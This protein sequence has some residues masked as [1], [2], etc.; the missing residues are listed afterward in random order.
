MGTASARVVAL[1]AILTTPFLTVAVDYCATD[2]SDYE[3]EETLQ[4]NYRKITYSGC[5][6]HVLTNKIGD[7]PNKAVKS[8]GTTFK[9]P[10]YP[11]Y[12][13]S[14]Q[15]PQCSTGPQIRNAPH[16]PSSPA[17]A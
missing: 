16:G 13:T 6:N 10:L 12:D 3:Y 1:V 5:P 8:S 7:N 15:V 17:H 9:V 11:M 4:N 14:E 2:G